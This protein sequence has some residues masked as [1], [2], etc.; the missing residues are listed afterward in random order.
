MKMCEFAS[1]RSPSCFVATTGGGGG[2]EEGHR[3]VSLAP[4]FQHG[5]SAQR[6]ALAPAAR[7][8]GDGDTPEQT[9]RHRQSVTEAEREDDFR[10]KRQS[11]QRSPKTAGRL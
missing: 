2:L 11:K 9:R 4:G 7:S 5:R 10:D 3:T 8:H 1:R 6:F